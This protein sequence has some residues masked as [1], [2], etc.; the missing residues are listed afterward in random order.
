M[1]PALSVEGAVRR[2][3]GREAVAGADLVLQPG[4]VHCLLGPSGCGKSTLLRLIAGLE[5]LDDGRILAG[6]TVLSG[7][8]VHTPPERR[9]IG[10]V[11][12]DY[13]LFPHLNVLENIGFGLRRLPAEERRRRALEQLR[14]VGLVERDLSYPQTLSGGEQ[15]RVALAR[16]LARGP[17]LILLDEPFSGLDAHLKADVRDS[18]LAA[19]R[20]AG[21]AALIVTHDAEEA[22]LM[23]DDLSLM[24]AGLILQSG[25]PEAVYAHPVSLPAARLLGEVDA[26]S[27]SVSAG[28]A[29][30]PF[31]DLP[32]TLPDGSAQALIRPEA[33]RLGSTGVPARVVQVRFAGHTVLATLQ[34]AAATAHARL[35]PADAPA[36][37]AEVSVTLDA[38]FCSV[39]PT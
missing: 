15:Q 39:L 34:T 5:P 26:V 33:Y 17:A 24:L 10:F 30:T 2:Y 6:A 27:A 32:T 12:Q 8:G 21:A 35:H 4:R 28:Q 37:G 14:R 1:S 11:F 20:E 31:G 9:D 18:T 13:A 7:D 16:A 25:A 19:L 22:L 29:R 36:E 23:A 38:R 3:G